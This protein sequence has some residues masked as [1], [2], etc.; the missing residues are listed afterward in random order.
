MTAETRI[1]ITLSDIKAVEFECAE[2][3]VRTTRPVSEDNFIPEMCPANGCQNKNWFAHGSQEHKDLMFL[4]DVI[5][6]YGQRRN[7]K[8]NIRFEVGRDEAGPHG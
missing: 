1:T 6:Q 4:I 5:H 8:Y 3:H 2:C 7:P